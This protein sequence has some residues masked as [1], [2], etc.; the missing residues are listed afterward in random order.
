VLSAAKR[1]FRVC[2]SIDALRCAQ[3][4]LQGGGGLSGHFPAAYRR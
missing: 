2:C 1:I 4:I 3:H